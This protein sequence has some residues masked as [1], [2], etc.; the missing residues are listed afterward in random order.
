[1]RVLTQPCLPA[2]SM[3]P[4]RLVLGGGGGRGRAISGKPQEE[5]APRL[6][7]QQPR[8]RRAAG[9]KGQWQ[10]PPCSREEGAVLHITAHESGIFKRMC[11]SER[12]IRTKDRFQLKYEGACRPLLESPRQVFFQVFFRYSSL[13]LGAHLGHTYLCRARQTL[14]NGLPSAFPL[15][16]VRLGTRAA[17]SAPGPIFLPNPRESYSLHLFRYRSWVPMS[18]T[19]SWNHLVPA[20]R[21]S[22]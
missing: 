1:M 18:P 8:G 6:C 4:A 7:S 15:L 22:C 5:V 16:R 20:T 21:F 13:H 3:D 19:V 2:S 12:S 14:I 17:R 11:G 9:G 10:W